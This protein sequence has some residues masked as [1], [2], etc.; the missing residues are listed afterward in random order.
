MP[1]KINNGANF[2]S[3]GDI[4][5]LIDLTTEFSAA[6]TFKP[7]V[8]TVTNDRIISKWGTT[9]QQ[10]FLLTVLDTD[11]L[12]IVI[13]GS[14]GTR[15]S[16]K[17][18]SL[19]LTA[20]RTYRVVARFDPTFADGFDVDLWVN[21]SRQTTVQWLSAT[22]NASNVRDS[23]V[24][25]NVGRDNTAGQTGATGEYSHFALWA[26]RLHPSDCAAYGRGVLP[27]E[28]RAKRRL[29][30]DPLLSPSRGALYNRWGPERATITGTVRLAGLDSLGVKN[31][32]SWRAS[33]GAYESAGQFIARKM[34]LNKPI[35]GRGW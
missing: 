34:Q 1:V 2:I 13:E 14:G 23:N 12:G 24:A 19:N 30:Y 6:I 17:T 31:I 33:K 7:T 32:P 9:G 28:I 15:S 18:S 26:S 3:Y 21:G 5:R 16:R 11:E 29:L 10:S 4:S 35:F 27:P 25:I 20:N 8:A 22:Y